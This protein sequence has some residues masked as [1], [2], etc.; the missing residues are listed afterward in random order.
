[1]PTLDLKINPSTYRILTFF[2][3]DKSLKRKT[4]LNKLQYV[5][6][7]N[8][9]EIKGGSIFKNLNIFKFSNMK[10]LRCQRY[11][12]T[13]YIFEYKAFNTG[14]L[15]LAKMQDISWLNLAI[16]LRSS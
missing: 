9:K 15:N 10:N 13:K 1:M 4:L 12:R 8:K 6:I 3:R 7:K 5:K 16:F 11:F 2:L 14:K